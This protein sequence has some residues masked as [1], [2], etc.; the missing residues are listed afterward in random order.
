MFHIGLQ[1]APARVHAAWPALNV[2]F[3][4]RLRIIS[5]ILYL[6][7]T[8]L[9][10]IGRSE[11]NHSIVIVCEWKQW[12]EVGFLGRE[13]CSVNFKHNTSKSYKH[14]MGKILNNGN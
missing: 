11:K 9:E 7:T 12:K 4:F 2:S 13:K 8:G 6:Y 5:L 1:D 3:L 14:Y 10:L